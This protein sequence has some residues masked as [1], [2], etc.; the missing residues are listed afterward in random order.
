MDF[1]SE[2]F[3]DDFEAV[4]GA[5]DQNYMRILFRPGYAVQAREL[6]QIQSII[7]NQIKAFGDNIFQ[8]G[9][10]VQGGHITLDTGVTSI[11]LEPSDTFTL[12]DFQGKLIVNATGNTTKSAI[13]I[14]TDDS[15][16]SSLT[17]GALVV[18]YLSGDTFANS[19]TLQTSS[20]PIVT[21]N[22]I[23][24][25][26]T[27]SGS[28]AS[29]NE[30]IFYV[31]G[32]F[33]QVPQQTIVLDSLDTTPSYRVGL[34]ISDDIIDETQDSALLDPAQES[35]NYQA[36]GAERYQ[37]NLNLAKRTLD[38]TDDSKFFELLRV[39]NGVI[40]NQ[41]SYP[42]Y[43]SINDTMARRTYDQSGD[44]TVTPFRATT[45]ND[46]SNANNFI[47]NIEPGKAYVKGYE[48]ETIGSTKIYVPRARSYSTANNFDLSIGFGN[49]MTVANVF[50]GNTSGFVN[51]ASLGSLD[52]HIVP[53]ANI[54]TTNANSYFW[55]K[56]GTTKVR[57]IENESPGLYD[58]YLLD[59]SLSPITFTPSAT[60]TT[61]NVFLSANATSFPNSYVGMQIRSLSGNSVGQVRTITSYNTTSKYVTVDFPF[62]QIIDS[63]NSMAI[64]PTTKDIDSLAA[65]ASPY[66]GGN[67][68]AAQNAT[69]GM[70]TCMDVSPLYGK[71]P[72]GNAIVYS[73]DFNKMIFPLPETNIKQSSVVGLQY[74]NR[75]SYYGA[76]F[77]GGNYTIT[78]GPS[79]TFPYGFTGSYVDPSVANLNVFVVIKDKKTS[80][81]ANGQI[82]VFD[83][84]NNRVHEDSTSTITISTNQGV[85]FIADVIVTSK[86]TS[87]ETITLRTKTL[88]GNTSRNVLAP[89]DNISYATAVANTA[90]VYFDAANG[91][92]WFTSVP[93][94]LTT[95]NVQS[96]FVPDVLSLIAVLDSGNTSVY[97]NVSNS[98]D[99]TGNF[100]FESGQ[101]DNYYDHATIRLRDG[102]APP[103]GQ[104]VFMLQY[105]QHSNSSGFFDVDSYS[106]NTYA[107]NLIATYSSPV[108]GQISLRDCIDFRPTRTVGDAA[109]IASGTR[110]PVPTQAMNIGTY[111]YYVPRI[112]RLVLTTEG[113]FK[114]I[115]GVPSKYPIL[116]ND[117]TGSMTLYTL[118]VPAYT[119]N[120]SDV[121]MTYV[122]NKRYTMRDIG[123][124]ETR[125][126][127]MEYYTSLNSLETQAATQSVLYSD[128]TTEKEKYGMVV[129]KFDDFSVGDTQQYDFVINSTLNS[130]MPLQ[131][132]T[133]FNL[134]FVTGA[135]SNKNGSTYTIALTE[136]PC[137]VQNTATKNVIVQPYI[138]GEYVCSAHLFPAT[139]YFFSTQRPP[140]VISAT[141]PS[142]PAVLNNPTVVVASQEPTFTYTANNLFGDG[143]NFQSSALPLS[144][145]VPTILHSFTIVN[146]NYVAYDVNLATP[147]S[148]NDYMNTPLAN[149]GALEKSYVTVTEVVGSNNQIVNGVNSSQINN[150]SPTQVASLLRV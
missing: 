104:T 96:L 142:A 118:Y 140:E 78:L 106:A 107:N 39:E 10:P 33:V 41:V 145:F 99:I 22:L 147:D 143:R 40:T 66:L 128:G 55:T 59:I 28:V 2:P 9:S 4:N 1:S 15:V 3:Y 105:F 61:S 89:T 135:G 35:F 19:N 131:N 124:I 11:L 108:Y 62:S 44:Y 81:F 46:V 110:T 20:S 16:A 7:Q 85:D 71:D 95:G 45:S 74:T 58:I 64:N 88:L 123:A 18:R 86:V 31:D 26:A 103:T 102:Y 8:N 36:P 29:I 141:P 50:S 72:F 83:S 43:S 109:F 5:K 32:F 92:V 115:Q 52:L 138:F 133:T 23:S 113:E 130:L 125:V 114:D 69:S 68:Y 121:T 136:T 127:N 38:S 80:T 17:S 150:P 27:A 132:P 12:S 126:S 65:N 25:N 148:Y 91:Y 53:S 54:V 30:G 77:S 67:V 90:N 6:T 139:D 119:Y 98:T 111:S 134:N 75:K 97:P 57:D 122:E 137:V 120:Y 146:G 101:R 87:G 49:F 34:E 13:V 79:E 37:F 48:H 47:I 60:G 14:A 112:D 100:L 129:D 149:G 117:T 82:V 21:A 76:T 42:L 70:L 73:T 93:S 56:I 94:N 63:N 144:S 116:Q 51:T 24:A 84:S